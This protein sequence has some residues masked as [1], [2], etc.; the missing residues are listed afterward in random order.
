MTSQ[1]KEIVREQKRQPVIALVLHRTE[2]GSLAMGALYDTGFDEFLTIEGK[3]IA[4]S[5]R[6]IIDKLGRSHEGHE[7]RAA[8]KD[9]IIEQTRRLTQPVVLCFINETHPRAIKS[10]TPSWKRFL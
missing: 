5:R 6:Q 8:F 2:T 3:E 1:D 10:Q 9:E 4:D 7:A